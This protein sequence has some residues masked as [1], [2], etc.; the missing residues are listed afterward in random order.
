MTYLAKMNS[1]MLSDEQKERALAPRPKKPSPLFSIINSDSTFHFIRKKSAS[2]IDNFDTI[3]TFYDE[4]RHIKKMAFIE[5]DKLRKLAELKARFPNFGE[6]IDFIVGGLELKMIGNR[7]IRFEPIYL[8]GE[9]G[10]GKTEFVS[11][12]AGVLGTGL[13]KANAATLSGS[14]SL[15]GSEAQWADSA[16][17]MVSRA[18]MKNEYANFI[19][20]LDEMEKAQ[21]LGN[22]GYP[23]NALFDL[24]EEQTAKTFV[25]LAY[26][27]AVL[28]NASAVNFIGAGNGLAGIHPAIL[29]RFNV[30]K[31]PSPTFEQMKTIVVNVHHSLLE[32]N[33]SDW[34]HF[35]SKD[36][37]D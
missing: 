6:V 30:F 36:I 33:Y 3:K 13:E 2:K 21:A 14:F 24:L 12:L 11:Q 22:G 17:G 8:Y 7:Y 20:Y 31:I 9:P 4:G 34:G 23:L 10:I 16:P 28:F 32:K 5:Q 26:T 37:D 25:D 27:D 1:P 29:S 15:A 18:M 19:F 35:F